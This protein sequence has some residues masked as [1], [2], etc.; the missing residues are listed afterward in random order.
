MKTLCAIL[1]SIGVSQAAV[2]Q[3][4]IIRAKTVQ[5]ANFDCQDERQLFVQRSQTLSAMRQRIR[6][7]TG[8]CAWS[9]GYLLV[10][11][12]PEVTVTGQRDEGCLVEATVVAE[13]R[14]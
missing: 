3:D 5:E 7:R 8:S 11:T 13:C 10:K 1:L 12:E 14:P 6:M 4:E 2:A 9:T